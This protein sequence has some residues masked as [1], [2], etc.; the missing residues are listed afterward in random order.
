MRHLFKA[1]FTPHKIKKYKDNSSVFF[2][3][4]NRGGGIFVKFVQKILSAKIVF[5]EKCSW[6]R[7][8]N[9][10]TSGRG[11][12]FQLTY[13]SWKRGMFSA[14]RRRKR[15]EGLNSGC[16]RT[17]HFGKKFEALIVATVEHSSWYTFLKLCYVFST[18]QAEKKF[19]A[20][21]VAKE[22]LEGIWG[23]IPPRGG[24]G[25]ERDLGVEKKTLDNNP[26][27]MF[28]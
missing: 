18:P 9:W 8:K 13:I 26:R 20:L 16:G 12:P 11:R 5:Y 19:E 22:F 21:I 6:K 14:R 24:G 25:G 28:L 15:I 2:F 23:E 27:K 3:K 4:I 1:H 7:G 10:K 17:F